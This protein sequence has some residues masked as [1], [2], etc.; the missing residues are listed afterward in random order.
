[1]D[2]HKV[3]GGFLTGG[4]PHK[5]AGGLPIRTPPPPPPPRPKTSKFRGKVR[6]AYVPWHFSDLAAEG[7]LKKNIDD[8]SV[9][10]FHCSTVAG[11]DLQ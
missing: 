8:L 11:L 5:G 9:Q 7:G 3:G 6:G 2:F 10:P 1:M 4:S